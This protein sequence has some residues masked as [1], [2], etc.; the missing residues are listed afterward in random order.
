MKTQTKYR[1]MLCWSIVNESTCLCIQCWSCRR[2]MQYHTKDV[3]S[4][5]AKKARKRTNS[6]I[7]EYKCNYCGYFHIGHTL[8]SYQ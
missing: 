4:Q 3:A 7:K 5:K 2:K 1:P 8:R 6:F